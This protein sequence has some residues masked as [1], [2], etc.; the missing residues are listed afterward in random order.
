MATSNTALRVTELDFDS[1]KTNLKTYLKNQPKFQDFNFE[2]SGM[3]VL[4]DVL[5]YNTHYM[6][7]YLNMVANEM[8]LDTA[9]LRNS[10][11]SHA[12]NLNYTPQSAHGA[13]IQANV[14]V[15]PMT[16]ENQNTNVL[17]IDRYT[18]F[19]ARDIDGV[20]Y[21]FVSLYSNTV[22][23]VDGT[24]SFANVNLQQGEVITQQFLMDSTTNQARRFDL[25]SANIDTST[26][27]V[28]VQASSSNTVS[29]TYNLADDITM[30]SGNSTV[31]FIEE[32]P[33]SNYTIYFGDDIIGKQPQDGSIIICNYLNVVGAAANNISKFYVSDSIGGLYRNNVNITSANTT[34]GG[35]D[36]ET[37]SQIR[38]RAPNFYTTQNR[39]VTIDDYKTLV[40]KD[41]N[42]I[43]AASVWSGEDN[44]P[45]IYGKV[46]LSLK[47]K[48]NYALSEADKNVIIN[49][50]ITK[51]SVLTVTPEIVD[52]DYSYILVKGTIK[53]DPR[54][55]TRSAN[56]LLNYVKAAILDYSNQELNTFSSTLK[57]SRLQY[58]IENSEQSITSSD[59]TLYFQKRV[60]LFTGTT[61]SYTANFNT[62]IQKGDYNNRIFT[63]PEVQTF[64]TVGTSRNIYFEEAPTAFTGIDSISLI[65][66]GFNYSTVPIVNIIGDGTGATAK[67][68]TN[69]SQV[70]AIEV[71]TSGSNYTKATVQIT[72]S[73]GY[74]AV[75]VPILQ[76]TTG[77]LQSYYLSSTGQKAILN[78]SAGTINYQTGKVVITNLFTQQGTP[79]NRY[80]NTNVVAINA[81]LETEVVKSARNQ[82][83]TIDQNDPISLQVN[84]IAE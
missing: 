82:I 25:P 49:D 11:I 33:N 84:I 7:Y 74:G 28:T 35:T 10:V 40:L 18:K 48:N 79:Q 54:L 65:S 3:S 42:N 56:D 13:K 50:L 55:T 61:T 80:Y 32:N 8:F 21:Q 15:T 26:L 2:G 17:T 16:N 66:S 31:Y 9:Q 41:Y 71:L 57:K 76:T 47:T 14:L 63:T 69:G 29:E 19:L 1:I 6:G 60:P 58:Y 34:Y 73:Q 44:D 43:D 37:I 12:K 52:P 62:S 77:K 53:Y 45:V 75:A 39:A 36:K 23:K 46:F 81:P 67:A 70:I 68:I 4:L 64:D 27:T 51:R 20:N 59:I 83:F 24:F 22:P 38:F 30:V 72:G 5:A 78:S